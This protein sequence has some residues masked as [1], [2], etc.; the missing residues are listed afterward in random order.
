LNYAGLFPNKKVV[1]ESELNDSKINYY[2]DYNLNRVAGI[3]PGEVSFTI[4][5]GSPTEYRIGYLRDDLFDIM[6]AGTMPLLPFEHRFFG[7]VFKNFLVE[8]EGD[9][10][11]Y[12]CHYKRISGVLLEELYEKL[13]DNY[14]EFK[15]NFIVDKINSYV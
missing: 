13:L 1:Y 11:Y 9:L 15:I 14:P 6:K 8:N 12:I 4:L 2:C 7:T 3:D 10:D 5:I